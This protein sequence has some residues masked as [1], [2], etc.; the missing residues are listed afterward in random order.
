MI[1]WGSLSN[2]YNTQQQQPAIVFQYPSLDKSV[3]GGQ[4]H[5]HHP[6]LLLPVLIMMVVDVESRD[7]VS[8]A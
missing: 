2:I 8:D 3:A 4:G 6:L 1:D 5:H 7:H